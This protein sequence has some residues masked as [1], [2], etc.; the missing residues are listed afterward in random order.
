MKT[1][2]FASATKTLPTRAVKDAFPAMLLEFGT[3]KRKNATAPPTPAGTP[4]LLPASAWTKPV[5]SI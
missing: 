4:F 2:T 5:S 1:K 3:T